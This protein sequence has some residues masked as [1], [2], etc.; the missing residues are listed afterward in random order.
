MANY[1]Q[2]KKIKLGPQ[3]SLIKFGR[4]LEISCKMMI[5]ENFHRRARNW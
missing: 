5:F 4:L 1:L 3:T 2:F